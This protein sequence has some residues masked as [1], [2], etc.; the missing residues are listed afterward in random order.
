MSLDITTDNEIDSRKPGLFIT[1]LGEVLRDTKM[2]VGSLNLSDVARDYGFTDSVFAANKGSREH[3]LFKRACRQAWEKQYRENLSDSE[4]DFLKRV[5][6]VQRVVTDGRFR[7]YAQKNQNTERICVTTEFKAPSSNDRFWGNL[8]IVKANTK[9][10]LGVMVDDEEEIDSWRT[11]DGV[12]HYGPN[13][14][15]LMRQVELSWYIE[16]ISAPC[17]RKVLRAF[18]RQVRHETRKLWW[19]GGVCVL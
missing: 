9:A 3:R 8:L 14:G 16:D 2:L 18:V 15:V 7:A 1:C 17:F 10:H 19:K 4:Y 12:Q 6:D 11:L 5:L 13:H